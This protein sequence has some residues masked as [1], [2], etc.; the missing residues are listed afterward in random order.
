MLL[1][2]QLMMDLFDGTAGAVPT[3]QLMYPLCTHSIVGGHRGCW[4]NPLLPCR[5]PLSFSSP[6]RGKRTENWVNSRY[7]PTQHT[8]YTSQHSI[9]GLASREQPNEKRSVGIIRRPLW[10]LPGVDSAQPH[11]SII[12][13]FWFSLLSGD[14]YL[15]PTSFSQTNRGCWK[16]RALKSFVE[17]GVQKMI[18]LTTEE[19]EIA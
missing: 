4:I 7:N 18:S 6:P 2:G 12:Y 11:H 10:R 3:L 19:I 14:R 17:G 8:Q 9:R 5:P 1:A 15:W 13:P 16:I